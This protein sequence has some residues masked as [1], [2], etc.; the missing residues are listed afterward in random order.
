M[1]RRRLDAAALA[2]IEAEIAKAELSSRAEL[3]AMIAP[4][5]D[6][7]RASGLMLAILGAFLAGIIGWGFLPWTSTGEILAAE[8]L[9]FLVLVIVAEL[10]PL[11]DRLTPRMM[12]ANAVRRLAHASFL[13]FGLAAT[14]ERNAVLFFVS[15]AEHHVEIIADGDI[16]QKVGE[17]AWQ[18]VVDD[19]TAQV[20]KGELEAGFITAI[21]A[22]SSILAR[23]YPNSGDRPNSF[24]NR[25]IALP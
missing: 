10:T 14:P 16:H 8:F 1:V 22:L 24:S 25:L 4:R 6:E 21:Q 19:F 17:G 12:K 15:L 11:G 20:R 23:H 5:A 2:R 3:V 9:A 13:E 18:R 7:Y